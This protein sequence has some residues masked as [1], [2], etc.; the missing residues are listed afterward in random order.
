[1]TRNTDLIGSSSDRMRYCLRFL[2]WNAVRFVA[3]FV[4]PTLFCIGIADA[5]ERPDVSDVASAEVSDDPFEGSE[6]S[7]QQIN[8]TDWNPFEDAQDEVP[9]TPSKRISQEVSQAALSQASSPVDSVKKSSSAGKADLGGQ[10][11]PSR[12]PSVTDSS[13]RSHQTRSQ[14]NSVQSLSGWEEV[15]ESQGWRL[16]LNNAARPQPATVSPFAEPRNAMGFDFPEESQPLVQTIS[17]QV[18]LP[19]NIDDVPAPGQPPSL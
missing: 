2:K 12:V 4:V 19:G 11:R 10:D 16:I 13:P 7:H 3:N 17:S 8:D 6:K 9:R 15:R 14:P 5:I 1:M 18:E